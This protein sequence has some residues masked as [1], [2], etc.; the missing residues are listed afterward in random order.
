MRLARVT[1]GL[2]LT[3]PLAAQESPPPNQWTI[4]AHGRTGSCDYPANYNSLTGESGWMRQMATRVESLAPGGVNTYRLDWS[5]LNLITLNPG[6]TNPLDATRH[7]V[8]LFDWGATS[9]FDPVLCQSPSGGPNGFAF[10]AGDAMIALLRHWDAD[11]RVFAL[12]GFSRGAVVVSEAARRL[13][14]LGVNPRQ[15][16]FIDGEGCQS[17]GSNGCTFYNDGRFDAWAPLSGSVRFD[18]LYETVNERYLAPALCATNLGGHARPRCGNI[19][20]GTAYAHTTWSLTSSCL[21]SY[22][23]PSILSYVI[24]GLGV[25]GGSYALP[26][27]PGPIQDPN[28]PAANAE[29]IELPF[30]GS[31]SLASLAGWIGQGGGGT[32]TVSSL[33][34]VPTIRFTRGQSRTTNFLITP[35]CISTLSWSAAADSTATGDQVLSL[36]LVIPGQADVPLASVPLADV[37]TTLSPRQPLPI[38]LAARGRV[39]RLRISLDGTTGTAAAHLAAVSFSTCGT[40]CYPNCDGSSGSPL[41]TANDFQCFLNRFAAGEMYANCDQ[42]TGTPALTANDFQ[43][44]LNAFA[45]G[46][47]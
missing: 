38:P 2:T 32:A 31:A 12:I 28:P 9:D 39:A 4:I 37:P 20:L 23:Q 42:S 8:V 14:S 46:C 13:M 47:R 29:P 44:F 40:V 3:S 21:P 18:N 34:G 6:G 16:L 17:G 25:S 41:L 36:S 30:N 27:A 22:N 19:N 24:N 33:S 11:D 5:T 1:L 10:A 26:Q 15:V 45:A 43:C 35:D 7:H